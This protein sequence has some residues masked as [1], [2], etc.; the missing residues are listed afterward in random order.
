LRPG[1]AVP[2]AAT[3]LAAALLL[4]ACSGF[5]R[6]VSVSD[7]Q[8]TTPETYRQALAAAGGAVSAAL[9]GLAGTTALGALS[10]RLAR[11]E[12]ATGAAVEQLDQV[13]PPG[14]VLSEHLDLVQALKML[15]GDLSEL[16]DAVV[17]HQLCAAGAVLARLGK[18][19]GLTAVREASATLAARSGPEGYKLDLAA[20]ATPP[21]QSRRL[22]N[23]AFVRPGTRTGKGELT[24]DNG[25]DKDTL[26]TLAVGRRPSI[27]VYVR[28]HARSKVTGIR[29]GSYQIYLTTGA[30]WDSKA[31]AFTRDCSFER[32]DDTFKFTTTRSAT[33]I[34][35]T[36]WSVSL[37]P[38]VGGTARTS[39]VDPSSFPSA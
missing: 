16:R 11:A 36:T 34:Q 32:F 26:I 3:L 12:Q 31:R 29:D 39:D 9:S 25:S 1:R 14:D 8:T 24:I 17:G 13:T 38:V 7:A 19:E 22:P 30:D 37:E 10:D 5:A 20:P 18:V 27:S 33:Q 2:T 6:D 21:E 4:A 15:D 28:T 35:W 23:G